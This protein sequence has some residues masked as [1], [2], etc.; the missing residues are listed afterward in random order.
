MSEIIVVTGLPRSGTSL[1]MQVLN[2][3]NVPILQDGVRES[4]ISNPQGY[5]ELE[6]VKNIVADNSFL[7]KAEGKAVKIVAPLPIY[8]KTNL[9][10]KMVFMRRD[11]EEILQSQEKMLSKDQT[12]ERE[13][14]RTIYEFHLKKTYRFLS[15]HDIP[16]IDINYNELMAS[17]VPTLEQVVDFLGLEADAES[18]SEVVNPELYRNRNEG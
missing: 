18:L 13:K 7:D 10:Y 4:D 2:K 3:A 16:F 14:F 5:F 12:S 15:E 9:K 17:P 1:M 8:M 6:D 11:I